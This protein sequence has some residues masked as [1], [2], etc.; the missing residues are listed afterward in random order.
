[1]AA[2]V[3]NSVTFDQTAYNPGDT[4]TATMV[5]TPGAS[6]QTMTF[7]GT[8]TDASTG[9]VGTL[10]VQFI[11]GESD[12]TTVSASDSGGRVWTLQSQTAGQ[13]VF[14]AVA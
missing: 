12:A 4:I 13:A 6:A 3:V 5:F 10:Q 9:E 2:P 7:T 1:M 11:V 8:A 14:T